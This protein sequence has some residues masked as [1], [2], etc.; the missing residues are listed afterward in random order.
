M[1]FMVVLL[2]SPMIASYLYAASG[3]SFA[4]TCLV[5]LGVSILGE[6]QVDRSF[7]RS[8]LVCLVYQISYSREVI[9]YW[10]SMLTMCWLWYLY[11]TEGLNSTICGW[12]ILRGGWFS[13]CMAWTSLICSK[14]T[15]NSPRT[16]KWN[17]STSN[18]F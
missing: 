1:I 4:L 17:F 2:V 5:S 18:L 11:H 12:W 10:R 6:D 13:R 14:R 8:V 16:G 15:W 3:P 7:I 9:T